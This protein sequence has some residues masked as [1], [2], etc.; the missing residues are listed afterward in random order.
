MNTFLARQTIHYL[1]TAGHK[2]GHRIHSPFIYDF[3]C[4]VLRN[5]HDKKTVSIIETRRKM[6]L[7]NHTDIQIEDFG[8]GSQKNKS[9]IRK[10]S[11]IAKTSLSKGKYARLLY[12]IIKRYNPETILELGTSLGIST[13]YMAYAA[14]DAQII[15]L[16][17]SKN[18][19]NIAKETM[20]YCQI[21]NVD[22]ITGKF[23]ETIPDAL[24][25]LKKIEFAFI[26][27]NHTKDATLRYFNQILPY[28]TEKTILIFDDISWSQGMHD[29]WTVIIADKRVSQSI[30]ICKQGIV[31]LRKDVAKQNFTIRY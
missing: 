20:Q 11:Y 6:L 7:H 26:D 31:F 28:C 9:N 3:I 21:D 25:K 8:A 10:I 2:Y 1:L 30:N 18:I 14:K 27:G 23:D 19:A 24:L 12:A 29:A 15:S 5:H 16:E 22:I 17:G 13:A 4:S